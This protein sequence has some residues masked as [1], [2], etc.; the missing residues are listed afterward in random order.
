MLASH[1][2]VAFIPTT[3]PARAKEFYAGTL[4]LQLESESSFALVFRAGGTMLRVTTVQELTPQPFTI[5]GW[6]VPDIAAAIRELAGRGVE[7]ERYDFVDQD[8]LG[9]W[10]AP[11]GAHVAWFKDP[12]GN[13]LSL[14]E[15]TT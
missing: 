8:E 5:L 7:F 15:F 2:I 6:G 10:R 11:V 3:D 9:V 1:D 14:A 4:G 12:D 13:T